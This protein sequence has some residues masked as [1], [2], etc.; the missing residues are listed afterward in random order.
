MVLAVVR[1][2][3]QSFGFC[4]GLACR[5]L[6]IFTLVHGKPV[7]GSDGVVSCSGP[8]AL[9]RFNADLK[10]GHCFCFSLGQGQS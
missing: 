3:V 2:I 4:G 6:E 8:W 7:L 9:L 10:T 5:M 1:F